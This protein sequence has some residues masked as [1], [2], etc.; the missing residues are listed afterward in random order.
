MLSDNGLKIYAACAVRVTVFSTGDMFRPVSN[1]M[2]LPAFTQ[3]AHSYAL[4][5]HIMEKMCHCV[6]F[7]KE[8]LQ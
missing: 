4:L 1:F 5:L 2:E 3:S 6:L 8:E 7:V